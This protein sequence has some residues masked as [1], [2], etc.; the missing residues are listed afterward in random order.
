M[1]G[2]AQALEHSAPAL[3][4]EVPGMRGF[5]VTPDG[6]EVIAI[7]RPPGTGIIRHLTIVTNRF[8]ELG[9]L[10]PRGGGRR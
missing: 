4:A 5:D 3:F 7:V 8:Q 1:G 10:V 2:T 9:R 6:G